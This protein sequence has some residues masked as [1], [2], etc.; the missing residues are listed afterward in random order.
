[1]GKDKI[2]IFRVFEK[3]KRGEKYESEV[4]GAIE[5]TRAFVF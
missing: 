3:R 5:K 4:Y 1:M 2:M